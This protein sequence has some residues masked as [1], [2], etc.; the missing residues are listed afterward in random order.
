[1]PSA[2]TA[3]RPKTPVHSIRKHSLK[4]AIWRNEIEGGVIYNATLIRTYKT[5]DEFKDTISLGFRDLAN[6]AKL[7]LDAETWIAGQ[8]AREKTGTTTVT[9]PVPSGRRTSRGG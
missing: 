1:M 7:L 9:T 3:E 6:A 8:I 2:T 4:V 5:G